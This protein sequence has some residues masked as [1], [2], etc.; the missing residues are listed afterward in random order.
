MWYVKVL[1]KSMATSFG[2]SNKRMMLRSSSKLFW[3]GVPDR[4]IRFFT[5]FS[6]CVPNSDIRKALAELRAKKLIILSGTPLKTILE[7]FIPLRPVTSG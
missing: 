6:K 3:N 5:N 1:K 4:I 2:G 7:S